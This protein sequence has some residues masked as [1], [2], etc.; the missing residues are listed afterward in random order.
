MADGA[1]AVRPHA[2]RWRV[3]GAILSAGPAQQRLRLL[4]AALTDMDGVTS[5][6]H[7]M[8]HIHRLGEAPHDGDQGEAV[9]ETAKMIA[10]LEIGDNI[11]HGGK[12]ADDG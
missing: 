1:C 11:A 9:E 12:R 5:V 6:G 2:P 10:I 4:L 8:Q 7:Q 3:P